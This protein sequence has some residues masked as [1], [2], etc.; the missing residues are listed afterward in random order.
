MKNT[1]VMF[2]IKDLYF[3]TSI[4]REERL[5][6]EHESSIIRNAFGVKDH[7][8][9]GAVTEFERPVI[10]S[11][12]EIKEKL[13]HKMDLLLNAKKLNLSEQVY[14]YERAVLY[15]ING[16]RFFNSKLA[17]ELDK[18]KEESGHTYP[19]YILQN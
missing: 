5:K 18:L 6:V 10:L 17:D 15:F 3:Q 14:Q 2:K 8:I 4:T 13:T 9:E 19:V 7:E 1:E 16:V 12:D 11:D